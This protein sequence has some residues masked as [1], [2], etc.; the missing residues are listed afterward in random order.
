MSRFDGRTIRVDKAAERAGGG[1]GGGGSYGGGRGTFRFD[2]SL[3]SH[4]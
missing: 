4:C 3:F 2:E 1:G